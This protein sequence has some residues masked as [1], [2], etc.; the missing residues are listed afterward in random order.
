MTKVAQDSARLP[1]G[2]ER[3][4]YDSD[5]GRYYF[6]DRDGSVWQ[7]AQSAEFSEMTRVS[8]GAGASSTLDEDVEAAPRRSDGY[9]PLATDTDASYS[10]STNSPYRTLFPFFLLIG[11]VL[12]LIWRLIL[13]PGLSAPKSVCPT[14]AKSYLVEPGDSCWEISRTHGCSLDEFK[15]VN[16]KIECDR[17]MPGTTV[18]LPGVPDPK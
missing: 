6:R 15:A 11:V 10:K 14:G 12:L 3:I 4:G 9:Q 2:M 5:T 18:C 8:D 1:E 17:L 13:A 16:K 7:G